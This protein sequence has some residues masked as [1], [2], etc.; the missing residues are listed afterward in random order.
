MLSLVFAAVLVGDAARLQGDGTQSASGPV[1]PAAVK[2]TEVEIKLAYE[3]HGGCYGRCIAY[4]VLIRG[5]G[6]VRYEDVGGEPRDPVRTR[7][8]PIGEV[9]ALVNDLLVAH[10]FEAADQY[11]AEPIVVHDGDSLRVKFLS[12]FDGEEWHL[13]VKIGGAVKTVRLY[14]GYPAELARLRDTIDRLGGPKAWVGK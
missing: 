4:N 14:L 9:V 3:T 6:V 5:D 7:T 8:V 1:I 12:G 10:F 13:T 2:L 11:N